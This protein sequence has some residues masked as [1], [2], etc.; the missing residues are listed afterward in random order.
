MVIVVSWLGTLTEF[1][2]LELGYKLFMRIFELK[3]EPQKKILQIFVSF[4]FMEFIKW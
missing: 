2:I 4:Y 3:P 1:P